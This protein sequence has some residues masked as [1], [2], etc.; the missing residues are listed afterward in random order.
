[1]C[2]SV[3]QE[4]C[5]CCDRLLSLLFRVRSALLVDLAKGS[6]AAVLTYTSLPSGLHPASELSLRRALEGS[7]HL[8]NQSRHQP[9]LWACRV[10]AHAFLKPGLLSLPKMCL[11]PRVTL[12]EYSWYRFFTET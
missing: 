2:M 4:V 10:P 1:M 9:A 12:S 6:L 7:S 11:E 8:I 3:A 5:E